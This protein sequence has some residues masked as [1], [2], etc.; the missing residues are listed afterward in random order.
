[1]VKCKFEQ[2]LEGPMANTLLAH[3]LS[4]KTLHKN[5]QLPFPPKI[6]AR[7]II[8]M[9]LTGSWGDNSEIGVRVMLDPGANV[10]VISQFLVREH[11]VPVMLRKRA[12]IIADYDGAESEGAGSA[13]ILDCTLHLAEHYGKESFEVSPL[14]DDH[15][16]LMPWWWTLQHSIRYLYSGAH[17]DIVFASPK[18]VNGTRSAMTE[19]SID[20]DK[21]VAYFGNEQKWVGVIGSLCIDE[22]EI[23]TLD[24]PREIPW[25]YRDYKLVYKG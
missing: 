14:Q 25:Q 12:E 11:K 20:Y 9:K 13:Y 5:Q 1:M 22:E 3:G 15:D 8:N 23:I 24:M 7:P 16:I 2:E 10:P 17:S 4:E 21:S 19:V 6:G 18:C